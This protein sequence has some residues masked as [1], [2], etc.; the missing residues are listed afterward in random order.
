MLTTVIG[1]RM[2]RMTLLLT[3]VE[4]I[5]KSSSLTPCLSSESVPSIQCFLFSERLRRVFELSLA[6]HGRIEEDTHAATK[7]LDS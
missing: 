4:M 7:T 1:Y 5:R 3:A 6:R 2:T